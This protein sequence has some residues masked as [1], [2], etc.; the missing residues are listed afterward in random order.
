MYKKSVSRVE[1]TGQIARNK[2]ITK[3]LDVACLTPYSTYAYIAE[4]LKKWRRK[5]KAMGMRI[6]NMTLDTLLFADNLIIIAEDEEDKAME[7]RQ[8]REEYV[9]GREGWRRGTEKSR[10]V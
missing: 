9:E 5:C 4:P 10:Q 8:L 7:D 3:E 1:V 2:Q 6:R